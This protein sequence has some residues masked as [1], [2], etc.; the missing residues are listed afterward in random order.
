MTSAAAPVRL[1]ILG[2]G[3]HGAEVEAY[4]RDLA[5][6]GR[7][8]EVVGFLDDTRL[9][10]LGSGIRVLGNVDDLAAGKLSALSLTHF[11]TAIGD[12]RVRKSLVERLTA[13]RTIALPAWT[14]IHE[15]AWIGRNVEIGEGTCLA[16]ATLATTRVRIGRHCILNIKASVSHDVVIG[17]YANVN[18]GV[19][20]C[21]NVA[22]G[23]GAYIGAGA[24]IKDKV[25]IGDWSVIGAGAAVITDIPPNATAVG[26]PARVI[27]HHQETK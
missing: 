14:L 10:G 7:L 19:T 4:A 5:L 11:M 12:N 26:V 24:V 15:S 22:I 1:V 17:D 23:E 20:I 8:V 18:P 13:I 25:S 16:P 21:G 3:F 6:H 9:P 27:K 2:A